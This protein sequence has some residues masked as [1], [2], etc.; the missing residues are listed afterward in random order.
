MSEHSGHSGPSGGFGPAGA[1]DHAGRPGH[2]GHSGPAHDQSPLWGTPDAAAGDTTAR[3]DEGSQD[4]FAEMPAQLPYGSAPP[5]GAGY[6]FARSMETGPVYYSTGTGPVPPSALP[7]PWARR[8]F[9]FGS[10]RGWR[11]GRVLALP[12]VVVLGAGV[13]IAGVAGM[14][15]GSSS[16]SMSAPQVA[17][18]PPR[19]VTVPA[20]AALDIDP[21]QVDVYSDDE[22]NDQGFLRATSGVSPAQQW[23][24]DVDNLSDDPAAMLNI[25]VYRFTTAKQAQAALK[26]INAN[27]AD[28][29]RFGRGTNEVLVPAKQSPAGWFG[30]VDGPAK[31]RFMDSE[32]AQG[33]YLLWVTYQPGTDSSDAEIVDGGRSVMKALNKTGVDTFG[34]LTAP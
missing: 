2:S 15:G 6:G 14:R 18:L 31:Y 20:L 23:E 26:G 28:N 24:A 4:A 34:K 12:V 8:R 29:V 33:P 16:S 10:R 3:H 17:T 19:E 1:P 13:V 27:Y 22:H 7:G 5:P 21:P 9:A 25:S 30:M 32:A 11:R